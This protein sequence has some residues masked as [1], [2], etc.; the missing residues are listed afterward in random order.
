MLC[1]FVGGSSNTY[2]S[3]SMENIRKYSIRNESAFTAE[4]MS[5]VFPRASM[6]PKLSSKGVCFFFYQEGFMHRAGISSN[7]IILS[8]SV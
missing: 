1:P 3:Y 7:H 4:C 2:D 5:P 8:L 6:N